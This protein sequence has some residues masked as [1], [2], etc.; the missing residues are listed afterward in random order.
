MKTKQIRWKCPSCDKGVLNSSRPRMNDVKRYCLPCSAKSGVL[1]ARVAPALDKQRDEAKAKQTAKQSAKRK[2]ESAKRKQQNERDKAQRAIWRE[3]RLTAERQ[4]KIAKAELNWV[5]DLNISKEAER[6]WKLLEPYHRGRALPPIEIRDNNYRGNSGWA[7]VSQSW[8]GIV[9]KKQ[10]TE[11]AT[12][13][14]LLHELTHMAVGVRY[15]NGRSGRCSAHDRT[16]YNA[17]KD[18]AQRRWK[19]KISF[20][21][22]TKYGYN[23]D[24]IIGTQLNKQG[25]VKFPPRYKSKKQIM[26]EVA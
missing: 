26:K 16:F 9:V 21:E 8:R 4:K 17:M 23:V 20:Y 5:G 3:Q 18:V 25:V 22:V 12:W 6:L 1:V 11:S 10:S 7:H 15:P 2:K 14:L 24:G 19:T 13:M